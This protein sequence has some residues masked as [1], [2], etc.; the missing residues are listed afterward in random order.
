MAFRVYID[1]GH[2]GEDPGAVWNGLKEKDITLDIGR[3]V[4][5]ELRRHGLEV[6]TS[7]DK[8][9][10]VS[11]KART[12]D[13]NRWGAHCYVSIHVNA[14]TAPAA[15]GFEVWHSVLPTSRGRI[16]AK[17]LVYWLDRLT[18]LVNRG[19]KSR[20]GAGGRD[21]YHVIRETAMPAVIVEAGFITNPDDN[22]YLRDPKNRAAIADAIVRGVLAFAGVAYKPQEAPKPAEQKPAAKPAQAK[23]GVIYRVQIGAFSNRDNAE[24]LVQKARR[25]GFDAWIDEVTL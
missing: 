3:R 25:A 16:L 13:A 23:K 14:A 17:H 5:A 8:D 7:R 6:K 10:T 11:L 1:P 9:V 20:A 21:Y 12:D 15:K 18:P 22:Q 4:A 2:G 24:A 19:A